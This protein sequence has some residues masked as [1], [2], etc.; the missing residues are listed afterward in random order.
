MNTNFRMKELTLS[1]VKKHLNIDDT[2]TEDDDYLIQLIQAVQNI[3]IRRYNLKPQKGNEGADG[4]Y[5][6]DMCFFREEELPHKCYLKLATPSY[7]MCDSNN[8]EC[9]VGC[10]YAKYK[11]L[12][13]EP[14]L[15]HGMLLLIG[16]LYA[17]REPVNQ[18]TLSKLPYTLD[19]L[20]EP[21]KNYGV[22]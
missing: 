1:L 12:Y 11:K 4:V 5:E 21:Y 20:C 15:L 3:I 6:G 7:C 13:F 19:Y 8:Y 9:V 17:N 10:P 16:N 2:F 22:C 18:G 14:A